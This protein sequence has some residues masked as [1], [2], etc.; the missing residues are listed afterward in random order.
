MNRSWSLRTHVAFLVSVILVGVTVGMGT[1]A[2]S[3][4]GESLAEKSGRELTRMAAAVGDRLA[5]D[6]AARQTTVAALSRLP[7][8]TDPVIGARVAESLAESD[9]AL[10]WIGVV[11]TAGRVLASNRGLLLGQDISSRPVFSEG[12][13]GPFIGDVH[14]AKLLAGLLHPNGRPGGGEVRFVDVSRP[15]TDLEGRTI[16]VL[17]A[18]F[19]LDWAG[20]LLA[21]AERGM[22]G[23]HGVEFLLVAADGVVLA[24]PEALVGAALDRGIA[25]ARGSHGGYG[26]SRWEDGAFYLSGYATRGPFG[27]TVLARQPLASATADSDR[28]QAEIVIW[29]ASLAIAFGALGWVGAGYLAYPLRRISSAA[30]R[31][32]RGEVGVRLPQVGGAVE[33]ET[34]SQTLRGLVDA[35]VSRDAAIRE[36]SDHAERDGLTHLAN[37]RSFERHLSAVT[38]GPGAASTTLMYV[39]L[40]NFK[41]VNDRHGHAAGDVVLRVVAERLRACL[42]PVDLAARLGGDE[43]AVIVSPACPAAEARDIAQRIVDAVS[44]PIDVGGASVTVGCCVGVASWPADGETTADALG[45]ADRALYAAK[46]GGKRAVR[47]APA[48]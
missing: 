24:G 9:P 26:A 28:L 40:D 32:R 6:M 29:G 10:A 8:I 17:A 45:A 37:R 38:S 31:M 35:L 1:F 48:E 19:S 42:R 7:S 13:K 46:R 15:V 27:W 30:E 18:H 3:R 5:A 25:P 20:D 11:D 4:S 21:G 41:P 23:S 14:P 47:V 22:T 16:G 36:L 34:L 2:A 12:V 43:F 44:E 33:V 39:D